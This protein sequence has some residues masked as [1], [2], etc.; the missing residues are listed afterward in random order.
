MAPVGGWQDNRL[1]DALPERSSFLF[2]RAV[3]NDDDLVR[4]GYILQLVPQKSDSLV[5]ASVTDNYDPYHLLSS[6]E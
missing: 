6:F 4:N 1:R 5:I 2:R 3:G